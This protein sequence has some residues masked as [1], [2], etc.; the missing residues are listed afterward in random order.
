MHKKKLKEN[1]KIDRLKSKKRLYNILFISVLFSIFVIIYLNFFSKNININPFGIQILR[2]SS[3]SMIPEFEKDDIIIIK[4]E[5][6]YNIG[7]IITFVDESGNFITHRIIEKCENEFCTKG[8]NN[9][10]KDEEKVT[11][12]QISGKVIVK[13]KF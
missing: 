10:T 11:Y 12:S 1:K 7:D 2:I 3:N 5:K 8:D 13:L 9:N 6:E 4:K